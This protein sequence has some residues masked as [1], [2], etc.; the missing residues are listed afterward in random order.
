MRRE[1]VTCVRDGLLDL[2]V[3]NE[4]DLYRGE[5]VCGVC[6]IVLVGEGRGVW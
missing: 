1:L 6:A 4:R 5:I 3:F 2:F